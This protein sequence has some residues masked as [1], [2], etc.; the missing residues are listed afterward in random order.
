[1]KNRLAAWLMAFVLCAGLLTGC[2]CMRTDEPAQ[3]NNTGMTDD[4]GTNGGTT[5]NNGTNG[6]VHTR[7]VTATS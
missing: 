4:A 1:M 5:E 6:S 7:S 3:D 2:G